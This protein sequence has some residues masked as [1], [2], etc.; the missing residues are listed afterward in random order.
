MLQ[1]LMT[2]LAKSFNQIHI[3]TRRVIQMTFITKQAGLLRS[4]R[5][6]GVLGLL[7]ALAVLYR[8]PLGVGIY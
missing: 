1:S 5:S 4:A 2:G 7:L 8:Y 6:W 3:T